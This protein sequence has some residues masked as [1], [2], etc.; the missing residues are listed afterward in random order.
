MKK[1]LLSLLF[2][3]IIQIINSQFLEI[4]KIFEKFNTTTAGCSLSIINNNRIEYMK[5]YGLSNLENSIR[6]TGRES[7]GIASVSKQCKIKK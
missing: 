4:D 6:F 7:F 5:G 3:T 2:I 1:L